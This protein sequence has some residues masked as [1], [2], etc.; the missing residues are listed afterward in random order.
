[1]RRLLLI[2]FAVLFLQGCNQRVD[3][4]KI[5]GRWLAENFRFQGIK[6]PISPDLQISEAQLA[7]G[8]GMDPVPLTG[9][10]SDGS[11]VT[12]QTAFGID[13]VFSF[14]SDDRIY[15]T[16]PL[17]G[18]RIYYRRAKPLASAVSPP[19]TTEVASVAVVNASAERTVNLST[20][21]AAPAMP[22]T[23]A[24]SPAIA[25]TG[26]LAP[27]SEGEEQYQQSLA[28]LRRGDKDAA[29]RSLSL[30][31]NS[32]FADW[33]RIQQE[34]A[35]GVLRGDIRYQVMESRWK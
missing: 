30:A 24:V 4:Q 5:Q 27:S 15:F 21:P 13:L 10:E 6:L 31:L 23:A 25:T 14:E 16:V 1:M 8:M 28:A 19:V 11:E 22:V 3:P 12:L 33:H 9:I 7:L 29:L 17:L 2:L 34:A 20:A 32:G 35:L 26:A 18:E